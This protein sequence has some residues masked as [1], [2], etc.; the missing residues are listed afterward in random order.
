MDVAGF[1]SADQRLMFDPRVSVDLTFDKTVDVR[2]PG[3]S[4]FIARN[5]VSVLLGQTMQFKQVAG[6]VRIT[7]VFSARNNR[8]TNDTAMKL[9]LVYQQTMGQ[10]ELY[11]L[12][13]G[14]AS[15]VF[16]LP[17]NFAVSQI[18]P[19]LVEPIT[20]WTSQPDRDDLRAYPLSGFTDIAGSA[21]S[22]SEASSGGGGG[23]GG[24]GGSGGG[25]S[26]SGSG[27]SGSG[28]GAFSLVDAVCFAALLLLVGRRRRT[29][30]SLRATR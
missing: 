20:F 25:G 29:A 10:I 9:A 13:P 23:G 21:F 17:T 12:V 14:L 22:V 15:G 28:G 6:G 7:P 24:G 27:S 1:F 18:S 11:G 19:E 16:D 30:S 26:G 8:F 5:S 2:L 3:E 4:D